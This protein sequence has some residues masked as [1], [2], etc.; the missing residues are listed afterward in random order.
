MWSALRETPHRTS[1][2]WITWKHVKV[3]LAIARVRTAR[4]ADISMSDF[5]RTSRHLLQLL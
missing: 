2:K 5:V 3:L 1:R 4:S